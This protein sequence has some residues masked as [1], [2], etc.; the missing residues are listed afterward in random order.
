MFARL[1][2]GFMWLYV[3]RPFEIWIIFATYRLLLVYTMCLM[4][5]WLL[6]S[7]EKRSPGN[8]FTLALFLYT[9]ALTVATSFSPYTNIFENGV[10]QDW[11]KHCVFF[12]ICM[13]SIKTERDLKIV[14]SGL[15]FAFFLW[16]AHSYRGYLSGNA[17]FD[18]GAYRIRPYG[19]TF[20]NA[21][22][23]GT[24]LVCV[25]PLLVPLLTL[26]KKYWHYLFVL[27]YVLL[28]LR[29]VMLTGSR[30]AF[31]MI[32]VLA[33][34]PALFSRYRFRMIPFLLIAAPLGWI[35]MPETMQN[36]YR[37]IWDSS[38]S[39]EANENMQGRTKGFYDGLTNWSNSPIFGVGLGQHGTALGT[40]FQSHNLAG[41]LAGETGTLGIVTFLFM[42]SCF[43]I[44]H[45]H[46]WKNYKYLQKN[47]LGKE[48][49]YC[50]RVSLAIMYVIAMLLLQGT[51][52][53][54]G[55]WF[56]WIWFG[57]FQA[58][59]AMIIQEK[60]DAAVKGT[61]LPSLP[62][63]SKRAVL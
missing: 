55:Y 15:T 51:G 52:L 12:V 24:I 22:D 39:E 31:V 46:V 8:I 58:L 57:A 43:G 26:C 28:T 34:L 27:G 50:W 33:I 47:N 14:V 20:A 49:L 60:V 37:T 35:A 30:G 7:G 19:T 5:V 38:V 56:H 42:L 1:L 3:H 29:S 44:N 25:L 63:M 54:N 32:V 17:F 40:P 59:A 21:N 11:L 2:V 10:Y 36:R 62:K 9:C 16:M 41:Q 18:A 48:G 53:H 4:L 13:T 23:Y 61:L 45:Y 6:S